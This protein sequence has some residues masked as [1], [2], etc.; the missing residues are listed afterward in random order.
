[1]KIQD[2]LE[3]R[4]PSYTY[5]E[6]RVKGALDKV[7]VALEGGTSGAMTKLTKRYERLDRSAKLLKEKRDEVNAKIKGIS[8]DLFDAEDFVATRIIDTVSATINLS[9]AQKAVDKPDTKKIDFE[10]AYFELAKLVPE[11]QEKI[12]L[13]ITKYTE[14]IAAKDTPVALRVKMKVDEG[15][16]DTIKSWAKK[17]MS[18]IQSWGTSYDKRLQNVNDMLKGK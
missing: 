10:A 14:I 13:I 11:L 15:V 5:T 2:L 17:F 18:T 6:K 7:T 9:A 16:L 1:M 8:D 4:V 3:A 12:D